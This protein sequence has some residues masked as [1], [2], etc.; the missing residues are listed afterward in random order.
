MAKW[1]Q[2]E[3]LCALIDQAPDAA[4]LIEGPELRATYANAVMRELVGRPFLGQ[5]LREIFAGTPAL[6][7][8]ERVFATGQPETVSEAPLL[9]PNSSQHG[10]YFTRT[11]T[12][13]KDRDGTVRAILVVGRDVTADVEGRQEQEQRRAE[14]QWMF[15]LF[16]EAPVMLGVVD[17]PDWTYSMANR[18]LREVAGETILVGAKLRELLPPENA[19][20][21]A[22]ERVLASG[23]AETYETVVQL[24]GLVGRTFSVSL[25][26]VRNSDGA[27]GA[28]LSAAIEITEQ[29]RAQNELEAQAKHLERARQEAVAAG[30]AKDQFL[31][32]LG[33]ELR[34]PLQPMLTAVQ[35]MR[36]DGDTSP[37]LDMLERE[38]RD[39]TR[40]VEDLL[41]VSRIS[42]G[43]ITLR[44]EPLDIRSI[45][46]RGV[47]LASPLLEH[48]RHRVSTDFELRGLGISGDPQRLAQVVSNLIQNAA[49][50]SAPGSQIRIAATRVND[51]VVLRISDDGV[52]IAPEML[53]RVFDAFV[54]VDESL[55]RSSGGLGIGLA[56]VKNI[57]EAHGGIVSAHSDGLGKGSTF[58]VDLPAIELVAADRVSSTAPRIQRRDPAL[59]PVR[60][61]I[62]DD[63]IEA[64]KILQMGL[65]AL[66]HQIA[67]AHDGPGALEL[68]QTALPQIAL[69]DI[70]LP[71]MDGYRLGELLRAAYGIPIVAITGYGQSVDH[72]RSR[73]AGFAAH[74]VKPVD[75]GELAKLIETLAGAGT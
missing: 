15:A 62:V 28:I 27:I 23:R 8:I 46:N 45:V 54:Q 72:E 30:R 49:K 56:I 1:T 47:E 10:R 22:I 61:L 9:V 51:R 70:G 64:T 6:E 75:L 18:G 3:L 71:V 43:V 58:V 67:V 52:G 34:N 41:D 13:L 57:V 24:P 16:E 50:Y 7:L 29:R 66:G 63:N 19:T 60:I 59:A 38:V 42:R 5:S 36:L 65:G 53:G 55:A 32:M 4:L 39:M 11:Y 14:L 44:L 26:P 2:E 74:L 37:A 12:P 40:L 25:V 73:A 33:H 20:L 31:A 48:R 21:A 35:V 69:L 68:A 17:A